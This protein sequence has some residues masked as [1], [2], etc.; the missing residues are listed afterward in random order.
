MDFHESLKT[1]GGVLVLLLFIPMLA[2]AMKDGGAGQSFAMWFLWG[3]LD[4]ILTVSQIGRASC[5]EKV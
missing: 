5:R 2:V 4:T 1:A 3:A